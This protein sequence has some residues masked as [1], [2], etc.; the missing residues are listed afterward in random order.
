MTVTH[1]ALISKFKMSHE[2]RRSPVHDYHSSMP[3]PSSSSSSSG[4]SKSEEEIFRNFDRAFASRYLKMVVAQRHHQQ[5]VANGELTLMKPR[6]QVYS[7]PTASHVTALFELPG[8]KNSDI[9]VNVTRDGKLTVSGERRAPDYPSD[10]QRRGELYPV[11]E[12]K[13]GRFERSISIPPGIESRHITASLNEGILSLSWPR[14]APAELRG[15]P[16][17]P[18]VTSVQALIH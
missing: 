18:P 12:F 14:V 10:V 8:L 4:R 9:N 11:Q 6:M 1:T 16:N 7:P 5:A 3:P 2:G 13:Y 17:S 15:G